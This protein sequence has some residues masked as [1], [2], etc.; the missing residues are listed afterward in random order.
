MSDLE[1]RMDCGECGQ[2]VGVQERHTFLDCAVYVARHRALT[3][4]RYAL[5]LVARIEELE[6]GLRAILREHTPEAPD[7]RA[8]RCGI[9][10]P[11]D[12][13]YPCVTVQEARA[14]LE[15]GE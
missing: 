4:E 1:A 8:D 5:E 6:K 7:G 2:N 13:H 3:D 10:S 15:E 14:A 11:Q 9:C 12:K